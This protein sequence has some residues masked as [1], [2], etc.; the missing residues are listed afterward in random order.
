MYFPIVTDSLLN[1]LLFTYV[2]SY[3]LHVFIYMFVCIFFTASIYS[4]T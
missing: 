3:C 1:V 2:W 4:Y